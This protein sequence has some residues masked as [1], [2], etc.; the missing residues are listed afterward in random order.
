MG[1]DHPDNAF[2]LNDLGLLYAGEGKYSDAE[3]LYQRALVIREKALG[4]EHP[5]LA[6]SFESYAALLR[7]TD[8][9]AEA[10]KME[11]QAQIIQTNHSKVNVTKPG[12]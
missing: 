12:Q 11:A 3:S 7:D 10:G 9:R 5:D 6:T 2:I 8:R 4:P 1:L